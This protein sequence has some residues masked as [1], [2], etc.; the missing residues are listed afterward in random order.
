MGK[1]VRCMMDISFGAKETGK[2][3]IV[4][5]GTYGI[6]FG[7]KEGNIIEPLVIDDPS[8]LKKL[9]KELIERLHVAIVKTPRGYFLPGG[10]IEEGENHRLCLERE[11]I[12]E[13]GYKVQSQSYLGIARLAGITP[14]SKRYVEL[15]GHFY[16]VD[17]IEYIGGQ[18]EDDHEFM[19]IPYKLATTEILLEHQRYAFNKL[20]EMED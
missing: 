17:I 16:I 5:P 4:R 7:M 20:F 14:K 19:W 15:E 18:C 3:Y 9:D 1:D 12:E 6:G 2:E 11:F 10:G 8:K 13:T